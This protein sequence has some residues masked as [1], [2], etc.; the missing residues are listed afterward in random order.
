MHNGIKGVLIF[1]SGAV[2]GGLGTWFA[3]KKYYETKADIEV[4]SVREAYERK[5]GEIDEPTNSLDG[6]I[7]GPEEIEDDGNRPYAK[8]L[9]SIDQRLAHKP[10][11]TDY[12]KFFRS[13]RDVDESEAEHP[14]DD[15]PY[16]D[17]EDAEQQEDYEN[18]KLNDDHKK[19]LKEHR[20]PYIIDA[21]TFELTNDHYDKVSLCY[22]ICDDIL[23]DDS[24]ITPE[25]VSRTELL[26]NLLAVSGFED[27]EDD[28]L[29]VRNDVRT[30]DY[31]ITKI[32]TPYNT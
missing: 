2:V 15:E 29:Y 19:A 1:V 10:P 6:E 23:T 25:E 8:A 26:G 4:E 28:I 5:V 3:V 13:A 32:F 30:T 17:E 22:Y 12:S 14:E 27:N 20:A 16:S 18:F 24:G 7:E 11:M 9:S 21:E 31:E